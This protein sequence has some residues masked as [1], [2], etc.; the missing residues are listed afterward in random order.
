MQMGVRFDR[1]FTG[2][3]GPFERI[4]RVGPPARKIDGAGDGGFLVS[5]RQNDSAIV[6]NRLLR[7][8]AAVLWLR[9]RAEESIYVRPGGMAREIL[10]RGAQQ[11]GV[12]VTAMREAPAGRALRLRPPRIAL[13]DRYGGASSSGW[14]RWLFERYEFPFDRVYAPGIDGGE[15]AGKY[16]RADPAQ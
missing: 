4:E 6:V 1:V 12:S 15:L 13:W 7:E 8:G 3:D 10:D 2:F 5:H 9:D 16:E 14:I 11:L